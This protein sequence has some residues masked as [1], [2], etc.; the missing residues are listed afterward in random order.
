MRNGKIVVFGSYINDLVGRGSRLPRPG[1]TIK[2]TSFQMGSGGKGF[3][4]AVAAKRAGG[5]VLM[6]T[7]VGLDF[8]GDLAISN[9]KKE[10]IQTQY[11]F[12]D[13]QAET[14]TALIV[15]DEQTGENQILVTMGACGN[16]SEE[17]I[18]KARKDI[19]DAMLLLIQFETNM[20]ATENC[21]KIAKKAGVPVILDPAPMQDING[22]ILTS[23]DVLTPNEIEASALTGID[24]HDLMD[25]RDAAKIILNK[26]VN[27]VVITLGEKG[28]Y[29]CT[30]DEDLFLPAV[31]Y[32]PVMDTT[33][34][35]DAFS[36]A[37]ATALTEGMNFF[38]AVKF[39]NVAASLSTSRCGASQSMA[40]RE[41]IEWYL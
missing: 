27:K 7:K 36:G 10:G 24:I 19:E 17:E 38:T 29:A 21:I 26:G 1:E 28:V 39:S 4:Q 13:P 41:E 23:V 11:V 30:G 37:L 9:F 34:A 14:G 33:G 6:I 12:R 16:I 32:A 25:V 31:D 40:Y 2:G 18:E 8:F 22:D 15:V 35:G 20:D 5:D 3:N